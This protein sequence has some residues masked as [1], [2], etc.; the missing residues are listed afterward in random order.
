MS[1][2]IPPKRFDKRIITFL[3]DATRTA[4]NLRMDLDEAVAQ[5]A[6]VHD[7][8]NEAKDA[9]PGAPSQLGRM[10]Q[11]LSLAART[12]PGGDACRAQR[13]PKRWFSMGDSD[14]TKTVTCVS[15]GHR[16]VF[17]GLTGFE[18]ATP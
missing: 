17:V 16:L 4:R 15:A 2:D 10:N 5:Q 11:C 9:W 12:S 1:W 7:T 18:P 14:P 8:I 13:S 6:V 3:T